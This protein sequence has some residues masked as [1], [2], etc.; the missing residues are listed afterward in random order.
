MHEWAIAMSVVSTVEKWSLERNVKVKK[1]I[2]SIPSL[3][4]LEIDILIE[5]FNVL[6]R[7]TKISE[8]EIDIFVRDQNFSCRNCGNKFTLN[9]I[10]ADLDPIIEDYGE[11][12]P[13]HV[14]PALINAFARC[15]KCRSHDF[16]ADSSI[17][18]EGVET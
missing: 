2:L 10:K 9:E 4:M 13:L 7:E 16:E 5:A 1:V 17:R 3:S 6:K 18:V 11:E 12:N 14:M 8:A 15:P